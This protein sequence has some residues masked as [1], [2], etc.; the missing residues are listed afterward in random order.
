MIRTENL[1]IVSAFLLIF[2]AIVFWL[3]TAIGVPNPIN[4]LATAISSI[5]FAMNL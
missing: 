2:A 3:L 4:L 5:A 1:V